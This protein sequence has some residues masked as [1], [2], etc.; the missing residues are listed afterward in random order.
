MKTKLKTFIAI[1]TVALILT[2]F[3]AVAYVGFGWQGICETALVG[4]II[5]GLGA[6]FDWAIKY[7]VDNGL[8]R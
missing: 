2:L 6:A 5:F 1:S 4:A 7:L 8:I 3:L